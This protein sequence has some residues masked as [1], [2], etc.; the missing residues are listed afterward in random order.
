MTTENTELLVPETLEALS[1]LDLTTL[2]AQEISLNLLLL[3]LAQ[4]ESKRI[5]RLAA[6]IDKLEE[7]IFDPEII[8]H[9][10][11][12]E[13]IQRYQLATQ[14]TQ[15]SSGYI[16][17]AIKAVNWNDIETKIMILEQ[18][19]ITAGATGASSVEGKELQTM[20]LKL[21]NQLSGAPS[22]DSK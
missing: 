1:R 14:A 3:Q 9:L 18:E 4:R 13:Q 22:K 17:D 2:K 10:T 19:G 20:A 16:R 5:G 7:E 21:L 12:A 6:V 11:A 8:P 15:V